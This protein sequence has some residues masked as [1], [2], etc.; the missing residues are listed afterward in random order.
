MIEKR[1][2]KVMAAKWCRTRGRISL[3]SEKEDKSNPRDDI[4]LN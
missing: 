2:T 3:F 1:K 4:N